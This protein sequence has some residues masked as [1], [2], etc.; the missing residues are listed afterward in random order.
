MLSHD[1]IKKLTAV[2]SVIPLGKEN[3][4]KL[5]SYPKIKI[6]TVRIFKILRNKGSR[7]T[8]G[9]NNVISRSTS[10]NVIYAK[11][12]VPCGLNKIP[13]ISKHF[14]AMLLFFLNCYLHCTTCIL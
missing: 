5:N 10:N 4:S 14:L 8:S 2:K 7:S 6:F 12:N 11:R 13:E 9:S 1:Q 3:L